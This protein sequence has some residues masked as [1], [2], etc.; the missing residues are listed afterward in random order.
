MFLVSNIVGAILL[1]IEA[2]LA[3]Y[4]F[5]G[6]PNSC[7]DINYDPPFPCKPD[8]D[9]F[10]LNFGGVPVIGNLIAFYP[11]LNTAA[12]PILTITLRNNLLEVLPIKKWL[13]NCDCAC[14]RFLLQVSHPPSSFPNLAL[15]CVGQTPRRQRCL[16]GYREHPC[17]YYCV[18]DGQ[19]PVYRIVHGWYLRFF[20]PDDYSYCVG[21]V[22]SQKTQR[23]G[24]SFQREK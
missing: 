19:P 12:V 8:P 11:M 21:L 18:V 6:L 7:D 22:R 14:A 24:H 5:S 15:Y 13:A 9:G 16:V 10:N 20:Y 2:Q 3:W 17:H 4:A 23:A 1:F